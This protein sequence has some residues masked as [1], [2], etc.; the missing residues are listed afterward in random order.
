MAHFKYQLDQSVNHLEHII[1]A[2]R[3]VTNK[4]LGLDEDTPDEVLVEEASVR[5]NL[6][7]TANTKRHDFENAIRKYVSQ[8][9]R[10]QNGC[11]RINGLILLLSNERIVQERLW[12]GLED[13]LV[14]EG[15]KISIQAVHDRDLLVKVQS[16]GRVTVS[17]LPRCPHCEYDD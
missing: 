3:V 6:I 1:P 17:R 14:F 13:Q 7:V 5:G 9:S 10:K 11:T 15:K 2:K 16:S 4:T 8:S 12:R